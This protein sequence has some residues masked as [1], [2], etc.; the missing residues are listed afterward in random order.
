MITDLDLSTYTQEEIRLGKALCWVIDDEV[1]YDLPLKP[2]HAEL[3]LSY[4]QVLDVSTEYPDNQGITVRFLKESQTLEDFNTTEYF[5]SL[6][7]SN[8]RVL[9]LNSYPYGAYVTAPYAK[10][11]GEKFII[12]DQD[13]TNKNPW[14]YEK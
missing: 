6:L 3:F 8:P 11:D 2:E 9:D 4:D 5:G 1:V 14:V 10:F 7:L 12:L 13:V